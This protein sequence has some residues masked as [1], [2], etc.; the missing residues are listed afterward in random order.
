[1]LSISVK[2]LSSTVLRK[3]AQEMAWKWQTKHDRRQI[4][5]SDNLPYS[6]KMH[7]STTQIAIKYLGFHIPSKIN[8]KCEIM[9]KKRHGDR[10]VK[11]L[12]WLIG[13]NSVFL[14]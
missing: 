14:Y 9:S 3:Y 11:V 12:Y 1:M 6:I 8:F 5:T 7:Y 13:R 4:S 2:S 10:K